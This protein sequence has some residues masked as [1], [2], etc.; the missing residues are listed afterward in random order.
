MTTLAF[1]LKAFDASVCFLDDSTVLARGGNPLFT[2]GDNKTHCGWQAVEEHFCRSY[3]QLVKAHWCD[4]ISTNTLEQAA[5]QASGNRNIFEVIEIASSIVSKTAQETMGKREPMQMMHIGEFIEKGEHAYLLAGYDCIKFPNT[6]V[7][8]K[9]FFSCNKNLPD[10][11]DWKEGDTTISLTVNLSGDV[12]AMIS[13]IEKLLDSQSWSFD[14]KASK[15]AATVNLNPPTTQLSKSTDHAP[16][17]AAC[18][19]SRPSTNDT[20]KGG[21]G[22]E[23]EFSLEQAMRELRDRWD[24]DINTKEYKFFLRTGL[25]T[26]VHMGKQL[27]SSIWKALPEEATVEEFLEKTLEV[28]RTSRSKLK[29]ACEARMGLRGAVTLILARKAQLDFKEGKLIKR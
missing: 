23:T 8:R 29:T 28:I 13:H 11:A 6:R 20:D 9:Y 19:I 18:A 16:E 10:T 27:T 26:G 1:V 17:L 2:M 3:E 15:T 24:E 25:V 7:A 22:S 5:A 4:Y 21:T 12:L 14:N